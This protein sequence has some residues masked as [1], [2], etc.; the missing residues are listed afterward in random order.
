[1]SKPQL[2]L[3]SVLSVCL[4]GCGEGP[5]PID[6][7]SIQIVVR[8]AE[9]RPVE[10]AVVQGGIDWDF[11]QVRTNGDGIA[12]LPA[13][14]E[15][16]RA[17]IAKTNYL[18][19]AV[20]RI[21]SGIYPLHTTPRTLTR[22]GG[23]AGSVIRFGQGELLTLDYSGTYRLYAFSEHGITEVAARPLGD[24]IELIRSTRLVGDTLWCATNSHG[25][26][27]VS[28][29]DPLAPRTLFK[30]QYT[31]NL[32]PITVKDSLLIAGN[33][34][35]SGPVRILTYTSDGRCTEIGSVLNSY[36]RRLELIGNAVVVCGGIGT[37]PAVLDITDPHQPRVAY[38]NSG[39]GFTNAFFSSPNIV[40]T[41][42]ARTADGMHPLLFK[43]L[44]V[45]V[46]GD[47]TPEGEFTADSWLAGIAPGGIAYG[48][49]F[50]DVNTIAFLEG[51]VASGFTTVATLEGHFYEDIGGAAPPYFVV[52]GYL[53]RLG[54]R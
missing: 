8:D 2:M 54:G 3:F 1:M 9:S 48:R 38:T 52:E 29:H 41:S 25:I 46:R 44:R 43:A 30:L 37:I 24:S 40:L 5:L 22:I 42:E 34:W 18:P 4:A 35:H 31:G 7:R 50:F 13:D 36:V 15:G 11:F 19:N 47:V 49:N 14:A 32:W 27:A 23:V 10:G 6:E 51:S 45:S 17:T 33:A 53:W 16:Q 28:L 26:Y 21:F 39:S 12:V 20:P